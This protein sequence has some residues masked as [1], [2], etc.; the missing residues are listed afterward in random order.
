MFG[1]PRKVAYYFRFNETLTGRSYGPHD[2]P[3][4]MK[5]CSFQ[6]SQ[7]NEQNHMHFEIYYGDYCAVYR[8]T[9]TLRGASAERGHFELTDPNGYR[10]NAG[11]PGGCADV[12][13][14]FNDGDGVSRAL[15]NPQGSLNELWCATF[16]RHN[17]D[18]SFEPI[19]SQT[20]VTAGR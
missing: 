2:T 3:D 1:Q 9:A 19:A 7:S 6:Q 14:R 15:P 12:A 11:S 5:F 10:Q 8:V 17:S 13:G 16:F 18:G 4:A 20:C